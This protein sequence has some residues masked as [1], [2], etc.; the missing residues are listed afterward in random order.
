M[1]PPGA[2]ASFYM[3]MGKA[4]PGSSPEMLNENK[5]EKENGNDSSAGRKNL[6][7]GG[8]AFLVCVMLELVIMIGWQI[9][10]LISEGLELKNWKERK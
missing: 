4:P 3:S 2:A 10:D 8:V 7:V 1:E 5:G 9:V 6:D